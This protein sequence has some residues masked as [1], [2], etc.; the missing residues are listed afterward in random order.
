MTNSL[1]HIVPYAQIDVRNKS[2]D[3]AISG[4]AKECVGGWS[5]P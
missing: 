5:Y 4:D 1:G 2:N 3:L